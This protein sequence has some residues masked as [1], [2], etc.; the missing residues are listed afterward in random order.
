MTDPSERI[1]QLKI[2]RSGSAAARRPAIWLIV[3]VLVIATGGMWFLFASNSGT[4]VVQTETARRP[5]SMAAAGSVLDASGYVVARRE[6][7]VSCSPD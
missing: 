3:P 4:V 7:T 6:A 2:D 5:P 1:K